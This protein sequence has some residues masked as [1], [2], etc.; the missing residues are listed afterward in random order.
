M[1]ERY[2]EN[3][4]NGAPSRIGELMAAS[5]QRVERMQTEA[6]RA[7]AEIRS[8]PGPCVDGSVAV[9]PGAFEDGESLGE[10]RALCPVISLNCVY[11]ATLQSQIDRHLAGL[12]IS[13][14]GVPRRHVARF[15]RYTDTIAAKEA[16]RWSMRG[17]LLLSGKTGCGKSYAA[18]W[19]VREYL[20][21]RIGDPYK[22]EA[23]EWHMRA[24][25]A[26]SRVTWFAAQ[27]IVEDRVIAADAKRIPLLI[28][29]D[30]GKES[31]LPSA[32]AIT[33]NVVSQRY[34]NEL[35]TLITTELTLPDIDARYGRA[36]V[37]RVIEGA[38]D[39]GW[40]V[41]C[42]DVSLRLIDRRRAA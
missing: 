5:Q 33:Q 41:A 31:E 42:G 22:A 19:F 6:D 27:G 21:G 25:S 24:E 7:L 35:P 23:R 17:F 18:A 29:D 20:K 39:G 34:D 38:E 32:R 40:V 4:A 9:K 12:M 30:L 3:R 15:D 14:I 8:C 36:V 2:C 26:V 16:T 10:F 37:E 28:L 11:G 13:R 1:Q